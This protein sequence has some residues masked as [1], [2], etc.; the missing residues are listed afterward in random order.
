MMSIFF[1]GIGLSS[2][3]CG[4]VRTP[5]EL[6]A[7]LLAMGV[8]G[9]IYHPVGIPLVLDGRTKTGMPIAI[10]GIFGNLGVGGAALITGFFIDQY[11]WRAGFYVPGLL[12]VVI[13]MS[14]FML[15]Q[16]PPTTAKISDKAMPHGQSSKPTG[17][18]ER[19][20]LAGLTASLILII[21]IT[22]IMGGFIYQSATFALPKI[23]DER[24]TSIAGSATAIGQ[25]VFAVLAIAAIAQVVVGWFL[26][27]FSARS[28]F[29]SV[30]ALQAVMF[31]LLAGKS[32][33]ALL[34]LATGSMVAIFAQIPINEVVLG[35]MVK[36]EHRST[37]FAARYFIVF[38]TMGA[39]LPIFALLH[40]LG[41]FDLVFW[42]MAG[43]GLTSLIATLFLPELRPGAEV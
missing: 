26:D 21:M 23:F 19:K 9:A 39:S 4:F 31:A 30:A 20:S 22:S 14:Y 38:L 15:F 5:F 43:C 2:I 40:N 8:F 33:W 35:R 25:F 12:S 27:R 36:P 6:G 28:V 3:V 11:G 7:A 41:G 29:M 10:N 17:H 34:A 37:F 1:I 42:V 24:L 13:G 18:S 16:A 32:E